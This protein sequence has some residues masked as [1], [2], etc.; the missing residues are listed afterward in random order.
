[1]ADKERCGFSRADKRMA[2]SVPHH[3]LFGLNPT[4]KREDF[5]TTAVIVWCNL[6]TWLKEQNTNME[7]RRE[8]GP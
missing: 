8:N 1:M 7:E 6:M 4:T 5:A 2:T 3:P